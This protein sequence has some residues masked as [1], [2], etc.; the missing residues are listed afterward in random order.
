MQGIEIVA[1]ARA[2]PGR[3]VTNEELSQTVDTSDQWIRT[4]TGIGQRYRC[5][6]ETTAGMAIEAAKKAVEKSGIDKSEI[7]IV[8]VATTTPEYAFPSTACLVQQALGLEEDIM[9]FDINAACAGFLY[10]LGIVR[11]MLQNSRKTYA[12]VIG[13]EHLS[14][15]INYEDRGSCIL[16]GDGAGAA[17]VKSSTKTFYHKGFTRGNKEFL[18]CNGLGSKEN[19]FYIHMEGNQVFRFAVAAIEDGVEGILAEAGLTMNDIDYVVCHQANDRIISHVEKKYKDYS[20][21][22]Y[23]NIEFYGNTSA[24]SIPICLD[25]MGEKGLLKEGMRI[26]MVG[27]G[28]GFTWSSCLLTW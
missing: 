27:F 26:L 4:R 2:L 11:S 14:K 17:I 13:S 24:A 21:V 25:E 10:G 20:A 12:L 8:L 3:C 28:A 7:G 22:F 15:I 23:K 9:S 5:E 1:T 16:F 18:Y 19:D 6:E